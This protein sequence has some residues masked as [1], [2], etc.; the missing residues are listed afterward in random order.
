[1]G[2]HAPGTPSAWARSHHQLSFGPAP[3]LLTRSV[4]GRL[5][6]RLRTKPA[7][8]PAGR[9]LTVL[10]CRGTAFSCGLAADFVELQLIARAAHGVC[11]QP[12][13]SARHSVRAP[14]AHLPTVMFDSP[15]LGTGAP[16]AITTMAVGEVAVVSFAAACS[17]Y[18][19]SM[20]P[21]AVVMQPRVAERRHGAARRRSRRLLPRRSAAA[22]VARLGRAARALPA[23]QA[24]LLCASAARILHSW[25]AEK[26][27]AHVRVDLHPCAHA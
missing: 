13:P 11:A 6:E 7:V 10:S 3:A 25:P 21:R 8:V 22:I 2:E 26:K 1:M 15:Q 5:A 14:A 27:C 20:L 24:A 16:A 18:D 23:A 12:L 9:V 19:H 4:L 17:F